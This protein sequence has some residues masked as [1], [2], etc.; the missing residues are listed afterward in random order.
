MHQNR[1]FKYFS[2][3][4]IDSLAVCTTHIYYIRLTD[5]LLLRSKQAIVEFKSNDRKVEEEKEQEVRTLI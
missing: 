2:I 4:N 3:L 5:F 1:F